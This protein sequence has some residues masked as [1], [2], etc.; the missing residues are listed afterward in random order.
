MPPLLIERNLSFFLSQ[1]EIQH[2]KNAENAKRPIQTLPLFSTKFHDDKGKNT[3][4]DSIG[5]R[6]AE[7][8]CYHGDESWKCFADVIEIDFLDRI[9]HQNANHHQCA[10]GCCTWNQQEYGRE[11]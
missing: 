4:T 11:E 9:N 7:Y 2:E 3:K 8:H 6:V 10:A 1:Y 5:N